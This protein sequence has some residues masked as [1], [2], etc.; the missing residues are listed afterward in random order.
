[1]SGDLGRAVAHATAGRWPAAEAIGSVTLGFDD[2]HRRRLRLATD[3]GG[4]VLLDLPQAAALRDGDGLALAGGGW[5]AV[6]AA[7]EPLLEITAPDLVRV[8]WH[9]GNRHLPVQLV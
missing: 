1:M 3:Q 8:A 6:R 7:P 9:L 5:V 2:R 4:T